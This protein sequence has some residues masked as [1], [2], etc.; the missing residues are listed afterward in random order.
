M[1]FDLATAKPFSGG[2]FDL[3]T[4]K[5][6]GSIGSGV[7]QFATI[8]DVPGLGGAAPK[9][10]QPRSMLDRLR[11]VAETG[12]ALAGGAA[13]APLVS[14]AEIY[15]TLTSG[16]FGTQEGIKSGEAFANRLAQNI[17]RQ[18]GPKT[19]AGQEYTSAVSNALAAT[20]LQGLPMP[21]IQDL[22]TLAP[23]AT[24]QVVGQV[25]TSKPVLAVGEKLAERSAAK[26][27]KLSQKSWEMAPQIDATEAAR[28]VG[29]VVNPARSAQTVKSK[30]LVGAVGEAGVN[31][32]LSQQNLKV[33]NKAARED[34]GLPAGA[35]LDEAA[36]NAAKQKHTGSYQEIERLGT[37]APDTNVKQALG[38]L[39]KRPTATSDPEVINKVNEVVDRVSQQIDEGLTGSD[40]VGQIRGFR[41]SANRTFRRPDATP[42]DLEVAKVQLGIASELENLIGANLTDNPRLLSQ[43]RKDRT[44]I[45]KINDWERATDPITKQVDP[46]Q[47]ASDVRNGIKLTGKLADIATVAGTFPEVT[48]MAP[49]VTAPVYQQLRRGGVGGTVGFAMGGGP[50]GAAVGAGIT[51]LAGRLTGKLLASQRG[52][53]MLA[54]PKDYRLPLPQEMA[55]PIP[56]N[57]AVVPYVAPQQILMPGEG[58]QN[59]NWV[60]GRPEAVVTPTVPPT[61]RALPQ[62]SAESTIGALRTE[63]ARRA[64]MSRTLGQEAEARAAASEAATR[65]PTSGEVI[66][67]LDPITGRLRE[68]SQGLKGATPETFQDF[69]KSLKSAADKVTAGKL[70]DLTADEK[71]AWNKTKVDLAEA[72]P[73]FKALSD[74]AVAEKMMDRQWIQETI[75]KARQKADAYEEIA[76]RHYA[77][78]EG[79]LARAAAEQARKTA[80]ENRDRMMMLAEQLQEALS[81]PKII[82]SDVQGPKTRAANRARWNQLA[83]EPENQNALTR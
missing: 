56:Q 67:D 23:A 45:A 20:G 15:G 44:A 5:P 24:R 76:N 63:D 65:R 70:F 79:E 53:N 38:D 28:R 26:A 78:V 66:L 25:A 80:L 36:F 31:R 13:T 41:D 32:E 35:P 14:A 19:E 12:I 40:V 48:S 72:A 59:P 54:M 16:K 71:I 74:K 68:V 37:L 75:V 8:E 27:E 10:Q 30:M 49:A 43:F 2:G 11:G 22:Q 18:I 55:P 3:A 50:E 82:R 58:P 64:A 33:W 51:S 77:R 73:E 4:A 62:P 29:A 57:R 81:R 6:A 60:Y 46:N 52:Q 69:G 83:P 61:A 34:I 39:R 17:Q 42:V 47:L 1:A 21:L 9:P 7:G